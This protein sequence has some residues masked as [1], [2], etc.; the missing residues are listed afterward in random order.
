MI[1]YK[2]EQ[3]FVVTGASSG[4]GEEVVLLLNRLRASVIAVAR[5]HER[6]EAMKAK[7][8]YPEN[9]YIEEKDLV[10]DIE[11][12][13]SF[14][15]NIK[16][17]YGKLQ[18]FAYCAGV[19][20][21]K[22]LSASDYSDIKNVFN[23]NYFAPI[24]MLKGFTDRRVNVG[25]GASAVLIS[26]AAAVVFDRGHTAYSGSKAALC[27]SCSSIAK[28]VATYGIRINCVLPSDIQTPMTQ[29]LTDL[30]HDP[31]AKY[32][33]GIGE[34][35]DVAYMVAFL[36]SNKAKWITGQNYVVDCASF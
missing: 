8:D 20:E 22:P 31:V 6:L 26:S 1:A 33:M 15:K 12:L 14:M 36:L 23:I 28:E 16:D 17:K 3:H 29:N 27:A 25:Q 9:I 10:N 2:K 30:R 21:I 11:N 19:G 7:A 34:V 24:L 35:A 5:N 13:P 32:P 4:I 18:G